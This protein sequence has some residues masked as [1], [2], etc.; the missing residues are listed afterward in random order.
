MSDCVGHEPCPSC[1]S[2]DNLGRYTD[3]HGYC[4]GCGYYERGDQSV[5]T[6]EQRK[7]HK[8]TLDLFGYYQ[9]GDNEVAYYYSPLNKKLVGKKYRKPD[10][11][12]HVEPKGAKLP[13]FGRHLWK[14]GGRRLIITEGEI[15]A[16]SVSQ[17]LGN[18]WP[19]V[20][21]SNGA[22][23]AKKQITDNIEWI[24]SFEQVVFCFDNDDPGKDA[25]SSCV[26]LISPGKAHIVRLPLKDPSEMLMENRVEELVKALW[27]AEPYSP[28]GLYKASEIVDKAKETPE[29][30]IPWW[31]EA[32]TQATYGRRLGEVVGVGAGT[33]AGKTTWVI[34][35]ITHDLESGRSVG[36]FA[37]EQPL[38]ETIQRIAS[39]KGK[40]LYFTPDAEFSVKERDADI[41]WVG[42]QELYLY[43]NYGAADWNDIKERIRYL[44]HAHGVQ[45]FFI[46]HLTALSAMEEDENKHISKMMVECSALAKE[47]NVWI[48]YVSHLTTPER[49]SHEEGARVTIRQF[50]GSRTIGYWTHFIFALERDQQD[51][52][53]NN[54][55]VFRVLKDRF[56][57]RSLG[58]T[59]E[60]TYNPK[61]GI[62]GDKSPFKSSKEFFDDGQ[63]VQ[64]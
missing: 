4:F 36:V 3:G 7:L 54:V 43:D 19:V 44:K 52:E 59:W 38:V 18:K 53:D 41:D 9:I 21:I 40:K 6:L 16:M 55:I 33:G 14:K 35:Q 64:F 12:F 50:R 63:K 51:E 45:F 10:K 39:V 27:G 56:T 48:L 60:L 1:G 17:V 37:F 25:T 28:S 57:G 20:S 42:K 23:S 46:D 5:T 30:G 62:L 8:R 2:R 32:L 61:T 47:L 31:H 34:Q 58:K 26:H 13:L 29:W 49:G 15:D 22:S 24:N 11:K